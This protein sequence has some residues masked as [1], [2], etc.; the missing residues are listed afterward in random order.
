MSDPELLAHG[1]PNGHYTNPGHERCPTCGESQRETVDL[2]D[3]TGEVLTWTESTATPSGV[4]RPNRIAIVGFP[5]AD[6]TVRVLGGTTEPVAVGDAVKPEYVP[7]LR[8]PDAGV[9][10]ASSQAWDGY[11]FRPVRDE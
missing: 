6:T 7:E 5:V 9:R 2:A 10:E 4:R 11:R 3:R 1:C 8:D